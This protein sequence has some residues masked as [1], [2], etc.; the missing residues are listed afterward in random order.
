[1]GFINIIVLVL[2]MAWT[3]SVSNSPNAISQSTHISIQKDLK[4]L[5]GGYIQQQLPQSDKLVFHKFWTQT[6]NAKN[7]KATFSY[8]F[9]DKDNSSGASTTSIQ[10]SAILVKNDQSW[11]LEK[12]HVTDNAIE[13][14]D[15]IS[16]TPEKTDNDSN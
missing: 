6:L 1:M 16:I 9:S 11:D 7:V 12:L 10:G 3:W 14:K 5:I 13:F 15:P 2:I 4:Q 8:S